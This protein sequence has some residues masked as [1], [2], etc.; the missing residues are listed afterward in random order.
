MILCCLRSD[1]KEHLKGGGTFPS[2]KMNLTNRLFGPLK[3]ILDKSQI[4]AFSVLRP[5]WQH[6]FGL[7]EMQET[8]AKIF[9]L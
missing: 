5:V 7:G 6:D 2:K 1:G 8:R 4:Q 3:N 9:K